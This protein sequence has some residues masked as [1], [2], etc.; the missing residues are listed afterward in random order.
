MIQINYGFENEEAD[1]LLTNV[2]EL[3]NNNPVS[4]SFEMINIPTGL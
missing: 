3:T 2:I 1:K 4:Q